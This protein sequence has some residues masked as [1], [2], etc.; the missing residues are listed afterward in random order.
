M[1]RFFTVAL[2]VLLFSLLPI[3]VSG[4]GGK[5]DGSGGHYDNSTGEY[6]YHHGYPAHSHTDGKCPYDF[7]DKTDHSSSSGNTDKL[8]TKKKNKLEIGEIIGI[9]FFTITL[10]ALCF[11]PIC[12]TIFGVLIDRVTNETAQKA[13]FLIFLLLSSVLAFIASYAMFQ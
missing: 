11:L 13:I 6:H 4:H 12:Y 2:I 3:S 8:T 9:I 10:S 1:K 5:T 7:D